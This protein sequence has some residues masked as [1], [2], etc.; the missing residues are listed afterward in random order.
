MA[1]EHQSTTFVTYPERIE[2]YLPSTYWLRS[3]L[4]FAAWGFL[5]HLFC[6]C[7]S[8]ITQLCDRQLSTNFSDVEF[9][10]QRF[11]VICNLNFDLRVVYIYKTVFFQIFIFVCY[12][13]KGQ[14]MAN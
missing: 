3:Q 1:L 13:S 6:I 5:Q 12:S 10:Q 14:L 9:I 4:I 2:G 8:I 11:I 7:E